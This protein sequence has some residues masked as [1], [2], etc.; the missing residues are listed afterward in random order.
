MNKNLKNFRLFVVKN[1]DMLIAILTILVGIVIVAA[2]EYFHLNRSYLGFVAI[3]A[4]VIYIFLK[5]I[6]DKNLNLKPLKNQHLTYLTF[7][8]FSIFYITSIIILQLTLYN[9]PLIYFILIAISSTIVLI[10]ILNFKENKLLDILVLAE[11]FLLAI[12]LHASVFFEFAGIYGFDPNFHYYLTENIVSYG[13]L[14]PN[15]DYSSFPGIHIFTGFVYILTGLSLKI[16][17]FLLSIVEVLSSI[18]VY[19]IGRK[20][21]NYRIALL[22]TLVLNLTNYDILWGYWITPLTFAIALCSIILYLLFKMENNKNKMVL[23]SLMIIVML[24]LVLTDTVSTFIL[25]IILLSILAANW[26]YT[27]LYKEKTLH[28]KGLIVSMGLI[29]FFSVLSVSYWSFAYYTPT[30]FFSLMAHSLENALVKSHIGEVTLVSTA[31]QTI[32]YSSLVLMETG[33]CIF[34]GL[35]IIGLLKSLNHKFVNKYKFIFFVSL[36]PIFIVIYVISLGGID[37]LLP[38]RW[39]MYI[40]IIGSFFVSI[41]IISLYKKF[42]SRKI[43]NLIVMSLI[44]SLSFMMITTPTGAN[45]DSALYASETTQR[46]GFYTSELDALNF[47][48]SKYT[49]NYS[50]NSAYGVALNPLDQSIEREKGLDPTQPST[51]KNAVIIRNLDIQKGIYIPFPKNNINEVIIPDTSF[52]NYL[53]NNKNL[54]YDNNQVKIYVN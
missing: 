1:L 42:Y 4:A 11:I 44:F 51:Y 49:G 54:I 52:L 5:K 15:V 36:L 33:Y 53:D 47:L 34:L 30:D 18:F 50:I 37:V 41:G 45:T 23:T 35:M 43:A 20:L 29:I 24:V 48:N 28:S 39:F 13:H 38:E 2:S 8:G 19:L 6:E 17:L 40:Y 16:S 22:A 7:M 12:N 14:P 21:F 32:K 10:Q 27:R 26:V 46:E 9:R 3:I 25:F 31:A